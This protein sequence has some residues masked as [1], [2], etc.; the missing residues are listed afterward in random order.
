MVPQP[1][2]DLLGHSFDARPRRVAPEM[3]AA[4]RRKERMAPP[5]SPPT[6][7]RSARGP[8]GR[9]PPSQRVLAV[10]C[11]DELRDSLRAIRLNADVLAGVTSGV[12]R[13]CVAA[14]LRH[15]ESAGHLADQ[16]E[17]LLPARTRS[18]RGARTRARPA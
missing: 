3:R 1:T 13:T 15:A 4:H 11:V 9:R 14:V 6:S 18:R 12:P 2:L 16:L 8:A 10:A 17:A 7:S 5:V